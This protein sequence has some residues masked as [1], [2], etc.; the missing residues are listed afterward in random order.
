MRAFPIATLMLA[1]A[2]AGCKCMPYSMG[3]W[4]PDTEIKL[5]AVQTC[6][7]WI[8]GNLDLDD[9][10]LDEY[11]TDVAGHC[12]DAGIAVLFVQ[13]AHRVELKESIFADRRMVASDGGFPHY[14]TITVSAE[15]RRVLDHSA[16]RY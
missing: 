16:S 9:H 4:E 3:V 13:F 15:G 2:I 7:E 12:D 1:T 10:A 8:P 5:L 6:K 14:F 11:H